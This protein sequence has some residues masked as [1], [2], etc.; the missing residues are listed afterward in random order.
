[1]NRALV[2]VVSGL[3]LACGAGCGGADGSRADPPL[4]VPPPPRTVPVTPTVI[5]DPA[6][7]PLPELRPVIERDIPMAEGVRIVE[8]RV[9]ACRNDY[10]QVLLLAENS[11]VVDPAPI[12]LHRTGGTW[13]IVD[14]GGHIDCGNPE[15]TPDRTLAAC[16]ALGL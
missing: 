7:C 5:G 4:P 1:V 6:G 15:G 10:A 14:W 16:R 12:F 9:L 3:I 13:E 11:G 2:A 8:L